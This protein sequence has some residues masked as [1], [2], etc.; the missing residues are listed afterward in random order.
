MEVET[1]SKEYIKP[2]SPTPPNLKTYKISLL[3]QFLSSIYIPTIIFYPNDQISTGHADIIS[4]RSQLLKQ[5]LSE[6]LTRFYPLAGKIKD[7]LS[8]DCN[9]E[10]VYHSETRVNCRLV[11]CLNR[12]NLRTFH[13]FLPQGVSWS[14]ATAGDH[15][16]K[17]QVNN[18]ACG[19]VAIGVLVC[20]M[21][22]DGTA[23]SAFLKAWAATTLKVSEAVICPNFNAPA[24]FIQNEA[25]P[26]EATLMALTMPL[27]RSGRCT[28]RRIV[29]DA[30]VIASLKAKATSSSIPT[31]T[32]VEVVSSLLVKCIM[33]TFKAKSG[34]EKATFYTHAVNLRRTAAPPFP[35]SSMGN[36]IWV[37]GVLCTEDEKM[38]LAYMVGKLREAKTKIDADFVKDL[39]GDGGFTKLYEHINALGGTLSSAA[40]HRGMDYVSFTSWCNFGL[41]DIDF[42]WG[43]PMWVSCIDS[44]DER[45]QVFPNTIML[46]DTRCGGGI[47][48]WVWLDKEDIAVLEQDKEL[49]AFASLDPSPIKII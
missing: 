14:G 16:A 38:E 27:L 22:A 42:G 28:G 44:S 12:P 18:F 26:M 46:M 29:F 2:S 6:T 24:I 49:L 5:S 47:E 10:G 30:S 1:I 23:F 32:R 9:D 34:I 15:V 17:I 43:K 33:A 13:L 39:Q 21:I 25:Y 4:Q 19:G 36:F 3:D 7:N 35:E 37:A 41:Y 45:E 40:S 8:I 11:D 31:P 48:A 20:H